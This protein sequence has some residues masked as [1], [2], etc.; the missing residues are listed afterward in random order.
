MANVYSDHLS[1]CPADRSIFP[2]CVAAVWPLERK[3]IFSISVDIKKCASLTP[4]TLQLANGIDPIILGY[5]KAAAA[6]L[7]LRIILILIDMLH[8]TEIRSGGAI[9]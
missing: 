1:P 5:A 8:T 2:T 9:E 7:I 3:R 4:P 6:V